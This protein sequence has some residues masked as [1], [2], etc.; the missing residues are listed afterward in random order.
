MEG[1][2]EEDRF[3][4]A[5]EGFFACAALAVG[6]GDFLAVGDEPGAF[7]FDCGGEAA[8]RSWHCAGSFAMTRSPLLV[9]QDLRLTA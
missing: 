4:E 1:L 2:H 7:L 9:Q 8:F 3:V 6:A 5:G